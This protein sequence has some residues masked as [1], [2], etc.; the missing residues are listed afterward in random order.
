MRNTIETKTK[1][2]ECRHPILPIEYNDISIK[3]T[4]RDEPNNL[5]AT[6]T[7]KSKNFQSELIWYDLGFSSDSFGSPRMRLQHT[8]Y[9]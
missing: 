7:K 9:L 8:N 5:P 2:D 3:Q 6:T 4:S 1:C